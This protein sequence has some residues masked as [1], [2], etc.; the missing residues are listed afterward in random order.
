M[1][2]MKTTSTL[3][4]LSILIGLAFVAADAIAALQREPGLHEGLCP[5]NEAELV[6]TPGVHIGY[7]QCNQAPR[8]RLLCRNRRYTGWYMSDLWGV[9]GWGSEPG[10][11][12]DPA[13][14]FTTYIDWDPT[15]PVRVDPDCDD[16]DVHDLKLHRIRD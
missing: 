3:S 8:L 16:I 14:D 15:V 1:P 11:S 6:E 2:G 7:R 10:H 13:L 9:W 5:G 12:R 4:M